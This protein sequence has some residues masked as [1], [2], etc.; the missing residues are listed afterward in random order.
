MFEQAS[1]LKLRFEVKGYGNLAAEDLWDLSEAK[2]NELHIELA[3]NVKA[4]DVDSLISPR[5]RD[6]VLELRIAIVKAVFTVLRAERLARADEAGKLRKIER[7]TEILAQKQDDKLAD[8]TEEELQ[9][10]IAA[11]KA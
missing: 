3:G 10:E 4:A 6:T 8:S 7:L 11:L 2:L 5:K 9:A 1:R